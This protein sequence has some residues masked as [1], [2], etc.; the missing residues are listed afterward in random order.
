MFTERDVVCVRNYFTKEEV[1][2]FRAQQQVL[3]DDGWSDAG[4]TGY[5][6]Y[7]PDVRSA[8]L[9]LLHPS[10]NNPFLM[11]YVFGVAQ[12]NAQKFK[13][14]VKSFLLEPLNLLKY[15]TNDR[16]IRHNDA[17]EGKTADRKLSSIVILSDSTEYEGGELVFFGNG[18]GDRRFRLQTEI[19]SLIIFPSV[20]HHQVQPIKQGTRLSLVMWVG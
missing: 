8:K 10:S 16:F 2:E 17:G 4:V 13:K 9:K 3:S 6:E 19:G 14:D 7:Q 20:M 5:Q 11:K 18:R 12:A 15:T 1:E